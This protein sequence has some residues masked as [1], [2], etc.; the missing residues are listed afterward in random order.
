MSLHL[1]LVFGSIKSKLDHD[2]AD[3][4]R[5][6]KSGF[7]DFLGSHANRGKGLGFPY[8]NDV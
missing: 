3:P 6:E 7:L 5:D 2:F 4:N 8:W 1:E